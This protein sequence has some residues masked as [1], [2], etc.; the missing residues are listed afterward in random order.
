MD[1]DYALSGDHKKEKDKTICEYM[2]KTG[3]EW[4]EVVGIEPIWEVHYNVKKVETLM[5]SFLK[6]RYRIWPKEKYIR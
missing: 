3:Q 2:V 1:V 5:A 6:A 4:I